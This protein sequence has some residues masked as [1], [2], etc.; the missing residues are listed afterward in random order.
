MQTQAFAAVTTN[1]ITLR[2][3]YV[4]SLPVFFTKPKPMPLPT[5]SMMMTT[6]TPMRMSKRTSPPFSKNGMIFTMNLLIRQP[7]PL[8]TLAPTASCPLPS[9][10]MMMMI[11]R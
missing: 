1:V 9:L 6:T 5:Y 11:D 4:Q 10:T 3:S 8:H 7:M 2:M